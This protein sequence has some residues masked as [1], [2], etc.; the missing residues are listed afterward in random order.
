MKVNELVKGHYYIFQLDNV[1]HIFQFESSNSSYPD[2][3]IVVHYTILFTLKSSNFMRCEKE[4]TKVFD[5][6]KDDEFEEIDENTFLKTV[7]M[8]EMFYNSIKL[9][10]QKYLK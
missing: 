8:Y 6:I 1:V 10:M 7:K 4:S 5:V 2:R 9:L 3:Y